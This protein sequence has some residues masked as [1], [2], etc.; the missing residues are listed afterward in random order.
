M[1]TTREIPM[2]LIVD[3]D[4]T[5]GLYREDYGWITPGVPVNVHSGSGLAGALVAAEERLLRLAN[6]DFKVPHNVVPDSLI[7]EAGGDIEEYTA[8]R[9]NPTGN[10]VIFE[11]GFVH[12]FGYPVLATA[13]IRTHN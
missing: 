6:H 2:Y 5:A 8:L 3:T 1:S 9:V 12:G 13:K 11:R 7:Q 4:G 10:C